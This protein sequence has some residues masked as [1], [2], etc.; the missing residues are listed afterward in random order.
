VSPPHLFFY[1]YSL[2]YPGKR[3]FL[4]IPYDNIITIGLIIPGDLLYFKFWI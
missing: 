1:V 4:V 2:A 3:L